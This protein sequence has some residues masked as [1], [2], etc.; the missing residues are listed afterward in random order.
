MWKK[1]VGDLLLPLLNFLIFNVQAQGPE[2]VTDSG[3]LCNGSRCDCRGRRTMLGYSHQ[4][5]PAKTLLQRFSNFTVHSDCLR[6]RSPGFPRRTELESRGETGMCIPTPSPSRSIWCR[7]FSSSTWKTLPSPS[8]P[9]IF[10]ISF[11]TQVPVSVATDSRLD[12]GWLVDWLICVLIA[13]YIHV[14]WA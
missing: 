10:C 11:L 9:C 12:S 2:W 8:P 4:V 5:S 13:F 1:L 14:T 3:V 6:C 7:W